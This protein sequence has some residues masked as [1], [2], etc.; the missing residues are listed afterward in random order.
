MVYIVWKGEFEAEAKLPKPNDDELKLQRMLGM[1]N[2]SK[3]HTIIKP[4]NI[5]HMKLPEIQDI[6]VSHR[7]SIRGPGCLLGEE[8]ILNKKDNNYSC[9]TRCYST[10][11][12]LF[13]IQKED[14]L[15]LLV[16][17][18]AMDAVKEVI[19]HKN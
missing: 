6:P 10:K 17:E 13:E 2:K 12:V 18:S 1:E 19:V 16:N 4:V 5:L 11:G 8:D 14:F 15:K 3:N 9:N 7:L